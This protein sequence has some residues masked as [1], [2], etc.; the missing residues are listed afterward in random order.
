M[1]SL[2][3]TAPSPLDTTNA[4]TTI[5]PP[6]SALH[7][8]YG[9]GPMSRSPNGAGAG[10]RRGRR[11]SLAAAPIDVGPTLR[12]HLFDEVSTVVMTSATLATSGASFDFFKSRVGATQAETLC[13]GSPFDYREQ[14]ELILVDGMADPATDGP[15]Y[16]RQ[17]AEM[18]QRY[19]ARSDGR[20]FVLFTSYQMM[21]RVAEAVVPWLAKNNLALYSQADGMPR[22]QMLERFKE[23]PRSVLFGTDSFW[24][25]VDVSG[26][27]LVNVMIARLPFQVPDRPLIEARLEAIR[28]RGGNPFRDYQL[29]EA[30]LKLKQG[31]G[32]LIRSRSDTGMVVILDPR[33]RTKPYGKTFLASLPNCRTVV[34]RA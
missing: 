3:N 11:T 13:L 16:E 2:D 19:V 15:R 10:R 32:R 31:F 28:Q 26:E 20:A 23:N 6:F 8:E 18:V 4:T 12:E 33:I 34:E 1:L 27:A 9:S 14:A 22:S 17:V 25:G 5:S 7:C 30:V 21:H 24:Q 29:P